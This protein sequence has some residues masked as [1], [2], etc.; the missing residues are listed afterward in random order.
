[1]RAGK[2]AGKRPGKGAGKREGGR[3]RKRAGC[4][5]EKRAGSR[6]GRRAGQAGGH[7]EG[8][9]GRAGLGAEK[10]EIRTNELIHVCDEIVKKHT[11]T[12]FAGCECVGILNTFSHGFLKFVHL[13]RRRTTYQALG[14]DSS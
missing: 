8:Q 4:R 11:S 1:M 2:R 5:A 7:G 13:S 14:S 12:L 3:A 9:V 6:A 10:I